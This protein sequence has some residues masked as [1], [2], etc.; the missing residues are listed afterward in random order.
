MDQMI[1]TEYR[2]LFES[3]Y[4]MFKN[5]GKSNADELAFKMT[6]SSMMELHGEIDQS[7]LE[8]L[9]LEMYSLYIGNIE[10]EKTLIMRGGNSYDWF[11][12]TLPQYSFFWP[13]YQ[14]YLSEIKKWDEQSIAD[15]DNSTNTILRSIGNPNSQ[16]DFDI[17][18][19]VLG[20][21]QSGKT[22]N[23]TGL[24]NKAY[25]VGYTLVVVLA[26]MHNDLRS[27]TQIRLEEEV[28][29]IVDRN[30]DE[31]KGV[32][33]IRSDGSKQVET[34]T[35]VEKDISSNNTIGVRN[36]TKPALLVVKKNKDVL[37]ALIDSLKQSIIIAKENANVP[38]L[39]IDDE[40]DQAS[41]DT[42][43]ATKNEDPKTINR[44]IRELLELFK[45][46]SYV[47]YTATPFAN[48]LIDSGT[49]HE[50]AGKDL[51]PKDFVVGLPRA[52]GYC[53]PEDYFNTTG[54]EEDNKPLFI[55][56]LSNLDTDLFDGIKKKEHADR[57][58]EIPMSMKEAILSF[59]LVIAI[60][61]LR[62]QTDQ[63]NSMLI[64]TSR[65]Q[66]VQ[67]TMKEIVEDGYRDMANE[68]LYNPYSE[69][70]SHL[71]R[72]YMEDFVV[73]QKEI[74]DKSEVFEWKS[75]L[76]E[77]KSIV[78]NIQIMEINGNSSDALEYHRYKEEG[79]NVIAIGGDKLSRGLTLEG[80]SISYYYRNTN[81]YDSL[82]QMGR[83]F[84][85]RKGYMDLCRIYTSKDI[86]SKFEHL[87]EVMVQLREEF[88]YLA[89]SDMT[90]EEYAIKMLDNSKMH[91][92][93]LNKMGTATSLPLYNG[94]TQQT[95]IFDNNLD[96]YRGNM[97]A[98]NKLINTIEQPFVKAIGQTIY[99]I[100]RDV[101]SENVKEFLKS[102]E[103]SSS[104][105]IVD[106]NKL[107]EYIQKS[108][109]A[110]ELLKFNVAVVDVT[111]ESLK[112]ADLDAFP[113]QL[114][115]VSVESAVIR[116]VKKNKS[117]GSKIDIGAI[118]AAKQDFV[119]IRP[120]L[121]KMSLPELR[122]LRKISNPLLLIYPL[123]P[124]VP[125]FKELS[126]EFGQ[127]LVPIGIAI[128]FPDLSVNTQ[129]DKKSRF[130]VNETVGSADKKC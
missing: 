93:S 52:K 118:V 68:L 44:L 31:K 94:S 47:G 107:L 16:E 28:V 82:M 67:T 33:L 123:H 26:G 74:D 53:G 38:V 7:T 81:M 112:G 65:L 61:I 109:D 22:A 125:A 114:G 80:L 71:Q 29:G 66:N 97:E 54:Y 12:T 129:F 85:F 106:S 14:R 39:I 58:T 72:L 45:R 9:E 20:Y 121:S 63:H 128:S 37:E 48:L 23:F 99:S 51:Y 46:K 69:V 126:I 89:K 1:R 110:G 98:T 49:H 101:S 55:R 11:Q 127:D 88:D 73:I 56:T 35:T 108:N 41:V 2:E 5:F 43:N 122:N 18:G 21:V 105:R 32:A 40:A 62:G 34:W 96:F 13:R 111:R 86:S 100:A 103:T 25:D 124:G 57:F 104:A 83:W 113:V 95:R 6:K 117:I 77:I 19:L 116:S 36:L 120:A 92:T 60:R 27:Q 75:V 115:K 8:S 4:H 102:Y 59:L 30:T 17:R 50:T 64:H 3:L 87:S 130:I 90:P 84:G 91:L 24:I 10:I 70:I 79:L 78:N 119:D 76:K 42:S 15:I